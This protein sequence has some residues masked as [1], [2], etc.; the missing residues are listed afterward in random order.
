MTTSLI[1]PADSARK[2]RRLPDRRQSETFIFEVGG[3]LFGAT[4]S[5]FDDGR[6]AELFVN[7]AK[8]GNQADTSA[9]DSAIILSFALQHGADPEAIRKELCRDGAG[10]ALGPVGAALDLLADRRL[11]GDQMD[12]SEHS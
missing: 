7:N 10:R 9:R 11:P 8:F 1:D 6:L 12:G 4:I 2:R 3:L 5:P